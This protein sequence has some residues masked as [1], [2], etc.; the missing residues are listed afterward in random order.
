MCTQI[1]AALGIV[2]LYNQ[3]R[4]GSLRTKAVVHTILTIGTLTETI[5]LM[6]FS[7][8][9]SYIVVASVCFVTPA[10]VTWFYCVGMACYWTSWR[11]TSEPRASIRP[12]WWRVGHLA[13]DDDNEERFRRPIVPGISTT[14]RACHS[15]DGRTRT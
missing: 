1:F 2:M 13:Q 6:S 10:V 12:R 7:R 15:F 8:N 14:A 5:S 11:H 9:T 4:Y 3:D